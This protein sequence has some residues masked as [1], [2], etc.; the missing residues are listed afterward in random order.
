MGNFLRNKWPLFALAGL[1][2]LSVGMVAAVVMTTDMGQ[3]R[4]AETQSPDTSAAISAEPDSAVLKLATQPAAQRNQALNAL[5]TQA[6]PELESYRA[7]YLLA[8]D[9]IEQGRGGQAL[10]LLENL[11]Q[12]YEAL[13][14]YVLL[15]RAQAQ[16]ATGDAVTATATRAELVETYGGQ[17]ATA[18]ALYELGKTQPEAWGQLLRQVP[19]HPR[20]V[21]VAL[22]KLQ[23]NAEDKATGQSGS[24]SE[25]EKALLLLVAQ[26]GVHHPDLER[27]LAQLVDRYG[28]G[29]TPEQWQAVG[30]GYWEA[31]QYGKAGEAYAKAPATPLNRYRAARG[32]QIGQKKGDAIATYR[33]LA[34]EFP[35]A[36]EAATGLLK[37]A[38]MLPNPAALE[39][40]DQ[41]IAGF[42]NRAGEALLQRARILEA[43][44]SPDSATA[45]KASVLSQYS[46]S[47]AAAELRFSRARAAAEAK[48]Y[49]SALTWAQQLVAENPASDL[50]AEASFWAGKWAT[51]LNQP[52]TA[53]QAFE[54]TLAQYPESYFA[55]RSAVYLG[56]DVGD[57]QDVRDRTPEIVLPAQR[58]PLPAGSKALQEL[59]LMGQD[60][61]AWALWQTEFENSQEPT[62]AEQFTDGVLRL[63]VG[64]NLDGIYELSSLAWREDPADLKAFEPL[65]QTHTYWQGVYPFP[66]API[67]Q[68]WSQQRQL[69]PLLVMAL[70]RQESRF[71]PKIRSAVGA[72]GLMQV[73]PATADWILSQIGE[74]DLDLTHPPDN[75]KLG[76][77]YLDYTH[78]EYNGNSLFAVAS[79][80]AGPGNVADWIKRFGFNDPDEFVEAIP[81][82]ETQNY[83]KTVFGG[84]WNYLRLYN[85]EIASQMAK[86]ESAE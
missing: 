2:A 53:R 80:N 76:T 41:V 23:T 36:P 55:W 39:V 7:R 21:E 22:T 86:Y 57:F 6:T 43:L 81:F 56:W 29:L 27:S 40:L 4:S 77:W 46:D 5:A 16:A 84:Y 68:S 64:D 59:Y 47:E 32:L 54:Q 44:N 63:G 70:I 25:S 30:F 61:D 65:K 31:G 51:R 75:V 1:S 62:V 9:L 11:E 20:S 52:D 69:N 78:R 15:K 58:L 72:T 67:I 17:A 26:H 38:D 48:D 19:A 34:K 3:P 73:M 45:A 83:V 50:A 35:Q 79:Y 49:Q 71:E 14:P 8:V 28:A 24:Q 60:A 12:E 42:P 85:P 18:D 37:L 66:F 82:G 74:T 10:P 33:L 13:A